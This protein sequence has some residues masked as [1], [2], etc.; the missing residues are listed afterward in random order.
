[1]VASP[2]VKV[3]RISSSDQP[4]PRP[5]SALSRI[6]A[7]VIF[8][9]AARPWLTRVCKP[10]RSSSVSFTKYFLCIAD[11]FLL[12]INGTTPRLGTAINLSINHGQG[13]SRPLKNQTHKQ[14]EED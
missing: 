9:A 5:T 6:Q 7:R 4:G 11:G 12:G 1:M 10:C 14:Q 8:R 3:V 2:T 13:T